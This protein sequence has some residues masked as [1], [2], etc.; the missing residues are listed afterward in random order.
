M[1]NFILS[2]YGAFALWAVICITFTVIIVL[3][4]LI[5]SQI[6]KRFLSSNETHQIISKAISQQFQE[7]ET[8][9]QLTKELK[10]ELKALSD[11]KTSQKNYSF[12]QDSRKNGVADSEIT[13]QLKSAGW[14]E[15]DIKLALLEQEKIS[16]LLKKF[17]DK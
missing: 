8:L 10:T 2:G 4:A 6:K 14:T 13:S 17:A 16:S 15:E 5:E 7:L 9:K 12:I 1:L 11:I 3:F